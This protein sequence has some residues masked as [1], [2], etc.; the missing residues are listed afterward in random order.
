[1]IKTF[2]LQLKTLIAMSRCTPLPNMGTLSEIKMYTRPWPWSIALKPKK[3]LYKVGRIVNQ[4]SS[5][6]FKTHVYNFSLQLVHERRLHVDVFHLF[7]IFLKYHKIYRHAH[8]QDVR[9]FKTLDVFRYI[10]YL[11]S[12]KVNMAQVK[13][14]LSCTCS[15][16]LTLVW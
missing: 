12:L 11:G 6:A 9:S 10:E 8:L 2:K 15:S 14:N 7:S 5:K 13:S 3:A 4:V 1:M 16:N